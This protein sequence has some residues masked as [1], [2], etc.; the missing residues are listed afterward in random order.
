MIAFRIGAEDAEV[1]APELGIEHA[2]TLTDTANFSAWAK[3]MANNSP[4]DAMPIKT[5]FPQPH[6]IG[7]SDAVLART[8]ARFTR[9]RRLV[10]KAIDIFLLG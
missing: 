5:L 1:L 8:R 4:M 7:R 3:L 9:P 6:F 10:E 2:L